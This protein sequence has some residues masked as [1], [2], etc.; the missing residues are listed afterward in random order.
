MYDDLSSPVLHFPSV[1]L[2]HNRGHTELLWSPTYYS[3]TH[4]NN[5]T[6]IPE[7]GLTIHA[8]DTC[9]RWRRELSTVAMAFYATTTEN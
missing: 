6:V 9:Y 1:V 5:K 3:G 7:N 2:Q 8:H 4:A